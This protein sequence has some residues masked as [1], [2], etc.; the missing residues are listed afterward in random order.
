M[1]FLFLILGL[2]LVNLLAPRG[3]LNVQRLVEGIVDRDEAALVDVVGDWMVPSLFEHLEGSF[4]PHGIACPAPARHVKI[5]AHDVDCAVWFVL[6]GQVDA[7]A[8]L[9][10]ASLWLFRVNVVEVNA[11]DAHAAEAHA[12]LFEM[13]CGV[14]PS[15]F[16]W[17]VLSAVAL[18]IIGE[19][20]ADELLVSDGV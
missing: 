5:A 3:A 18:D 12:R 2:H 17:R 10:E 4:V 16:S 8:E 11:H 19:A 13:H 14:M 9:E 15:D 1:E 7:L 20:R 6:S